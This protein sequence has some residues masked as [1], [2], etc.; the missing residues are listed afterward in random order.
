M[1]L[2]DRSISSPIRIPRRTQTMWRARTDR[3]S[4]ITLRCLHTSYSTSTSPPTSIFPP[5][6]TSHLNPWPVPQDMVETW[7][8]SGKQMQSIG[9]GLDT[10]NNQQ[11]GLGVARTPL[12]SCKA[13][14]SNL[15]SCRVQL[16]NL[17]N[18]S[19]PA[20]E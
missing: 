7:T 18:L 13:S 12:G 1:L 4:P 17:D 9:S 10:R 20:I 11:R 19:M 2:G 16:W 14:L 15:M 5:P 6:S 8:N 3:Y